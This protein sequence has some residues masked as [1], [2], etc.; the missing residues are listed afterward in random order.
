MIYMI[1]YQNW[2]TNFLILYYSYDSVK[3]NFPF[4]GVIALGKLCCVSKIYGVLSILCFP[5][6]F[7][8]SCCSYQGGLIVPLLDH[9]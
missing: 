5:Y 2:L 9:V 1:Y 3:N 6:C 4:F 8:N 7:H